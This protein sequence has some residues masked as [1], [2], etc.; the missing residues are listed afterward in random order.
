MSED[1]EL[2]NVVKRELGNRGY[3]VMMN[4]HREGDLVVGSVSVTSAATDET[5]ARF[6]GVGTLENLR[7]CFGVEAE[8]TMR[9]VVAKAIG[10]MEGVKNLVPSFV[11][12]PARK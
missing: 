7:L 9:D 12:A 4:A 5:V 10:T 6:V 11:L 3:V 1:A 2:I 8:G